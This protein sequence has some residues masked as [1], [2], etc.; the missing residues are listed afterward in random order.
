[1]NVWDV[2]TLGFL[3]WWLQMVVGLTV[4][5]VFLWWFI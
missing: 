5:F 3:P 4:W 2:L 1:M